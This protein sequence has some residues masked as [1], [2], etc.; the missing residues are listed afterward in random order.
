ML[1]K[2]TAAA[3]AVPLIALGVSMIEAPAA[4]SS[5]TDGMSLN[6]PG[7]DCP[8]IDGCGDPANPDHKKPPKKKGKKGGSKDKK[9]KKGKKGGKKS[10]KK[11]PPR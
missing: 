1:K 8:L 11:H 10:G 6:A 3:A 4:L 2:I 9:G 7:D 5:P